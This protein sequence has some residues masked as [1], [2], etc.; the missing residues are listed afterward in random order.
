MTMYSFIWTHEYYTHM[1]IYMFGLVCS[2]SVMSD[3]LWPHGLYSL[4]DSFAQDF[5]DKN[6]GEG[7]HFLFQGIFLTLGLN[8]HLLP[9]LAGGSFTTEPLGKPM[10]METCILYIHV[11]AHCTYTVLCIYK[12]I[13]I[14]NSLGIYS[15]LLVNLV[16]EI[17][18]YFYILVCYSEFNSV[19]AKYL[20]YHSHMIFK[21][22]RWF[23]ICP[24]LKV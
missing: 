5:P 4:P 24:A 3:S 21:F 9:E 12:N 7:C 17:Y 14:D 6:I 23:S 16:P 8:T 19:S 1:C 2:C 15:D 18:L 20:G 22:L 10:H 13:C 11:Y